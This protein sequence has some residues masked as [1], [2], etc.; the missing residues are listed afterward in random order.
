MP[1]DTV[2]FAAEASPGAPSWFTTTTV[3]HPSEVV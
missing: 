3:R 2:H 1:L